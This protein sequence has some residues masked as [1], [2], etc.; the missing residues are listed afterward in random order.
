MS[1]IGYVNYY[2]WR[3]SAGRTWRSIVSIFKRKNACTCR[4]RLCSSRIGHSR[5]GKNISHVLSK[6]PSVFRFWS[7]YIKFY[8]M[9]GLVVSIYT[10]C[11]RDGKC[12]LSGRSRWSCTPSE[13]ITCD[14]GQQ[15]GK[16]IRPCVP[17][18][19]IPWRK[20]I[21]PECLYHGPASLHL[22][23]MP[24]SHLQAGLSCRKETVPYSCLLDIQK[25]CFGVNCEKMKLR[26]YTKES[27]VSRK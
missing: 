5:C 25:S 26:G 8:W 6:R 2:P 13:S 20:N 17:V 3:S 27:Q 9:W 23:D 19:W 11:C 1:T 14:T 10:S 18:F 24:A 16:R 7:S 21:C 12:S 15:D 4:N 22:G